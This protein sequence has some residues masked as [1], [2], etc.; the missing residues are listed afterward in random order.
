MPK[1]NSRLLIAVMVFV[2]LLIVWAWPT[3][4]PVG[5][6]GLDPAPLTPPGSALP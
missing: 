6:W 4:V 2:W 1:E 3:T 5:S